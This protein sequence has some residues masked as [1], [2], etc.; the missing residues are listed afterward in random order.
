MCARPTAK[1]LGAST[2]IFGLIGFYIS[3]LFTNW[4][5]MGQKDHNQRIF[6]ILFS[7]WFIILNIDFSD[8]ITKADNFG[9][10]GGGTTGF[11]AGLAISEQYDADARNN[12]RIPD[13]LLTK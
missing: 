11:L 13:R 8:Q 5:Y 10:L 1:G 12:G 4:H 2:S 6:L 3:Y 9:H 7:L